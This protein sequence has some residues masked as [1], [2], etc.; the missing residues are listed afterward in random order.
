MAISLQ[1]GVAWRLLRHTAVRELQPL[2][3]LLFAVS[4]CATAAPD[5]IDP[6]YESTKSDGNRPKLKVIDHDGVDVDEPSDLTFANDK[7]YTVSDRHSKIYEISKGGNVRDELDVQARDLEALAFDG[8]RFVIADENDDKVWFVNKDGERTESFEI[9]GVDDGNSGIE[10]LA[11]DDRGHLFVA[12]EKDP[13][14]IYELNDSGDV[15]D[16]KKIDVDD[17]SA[18]A[19]CDKDGHLYALSDAE[20][21][22][23]RLDKDLDIDSAWRIP[24]DN[25][26][27]IAFDG[28]TLYVISDREEKIYE[29][30][31]DLD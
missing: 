4:A 25:P 22:L 17:L 27:G 20:H 8:E 15:I 13:A 3:I 24:V 1:F 6:Y 7:L 9:D 2:C 23:Y 29:F 26:E 16:D 19:W 5:E 14:K 12:K 21:S 31:L 28:K 11:F 18:L 30:E 10:G